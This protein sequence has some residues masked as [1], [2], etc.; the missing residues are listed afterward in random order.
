[1][2]ANAEFLA[3]VTPQ[4]REA[5]L[6]SIAARYGITTAQAHTEVCADGAQ[7]LLDYL[8]EPQRSATAVLMQRHGA[9]T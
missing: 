3:R 8:V 4:A 1:M 5:I 7:D 6:A 2:N 9:R